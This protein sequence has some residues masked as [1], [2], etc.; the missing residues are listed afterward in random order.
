V[1]RVPGS[2]GAARSG[3]THSL[4]TAYRLGDT[5]P[6]V[7]EVR[8]K[9]GLLGLLGEEPG[10]SGQPVEARYDQD[11]D[12]AVREFQQQRGITVDGV[13]GPL[14]YR[15][16]DEAR[17]RLG[18]RILS[19]AVS[20]LM[21]GDDVAVLQQRLLDMGF[22]CG[23][24]DGIFGRETAAALQEFQRNVGLVADGTCGPATL[25]ALDRLTHTVVGGRPHVLRDD[26]MLHASGPVLAGRVVVLDPGHG[27][28][29]RG[30]VAH[31]FD[32]AVIVEDI[33]SRIE[34]R[35]AATGVFAFLTRGSDM[36][37]DEA[38]RAAFANAAE[39]DLVISLHVDASTSPRATGVATYFYGN[40]RYG[41][42][43]AIGER[44]A[45]LVQREV[46]AR[47]DLTDCRTHGKTWDLLRRTR[48]PAVRIEVGYLTSG[49]DAARLADADFR[50]AVADGIVAAMHRLY[51]PADEDA[52]TGTFRIPEA[53]VK[54]R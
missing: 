2:P 38:E 50:D 20:H 25:K 34:G 47:T 13:V 7:A 23:R 51:L 15:L 30:V 18:D 53:L 31:G 33:A 27:G 6:A 39:A 36:D 54:P 29:D 21:A 35:L 52:A 43:S 41:H 9:L 3:N 4:P 49:G 32:E 44:F 1:S 28:P 17:W 37:I 24:V 22:D 48:M 16:L 11:V 42:S 10:G 12:R 8:H 5:G 45:D 46:V 26:A 14:T 19:Y 40:D